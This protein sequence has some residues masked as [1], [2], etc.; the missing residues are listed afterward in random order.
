MLL[1]FALEQCS[2]CF[3]R[4]SDLFIAHKLSLLAA[5]LKQKKGLG[6]LAELMEKG[7]KNLCCCGLSPKFLLH[8]QK[9]GRG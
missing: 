9:V 8:L 2:F 5:S 6:L 1:C 4:E 7:A 3:V